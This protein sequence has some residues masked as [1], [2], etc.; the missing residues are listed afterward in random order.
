V[1]AGLLG[2]HFQEGF[3]LLPCLPIYAR[4]G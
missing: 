3:H 4:A 2:A 1:V